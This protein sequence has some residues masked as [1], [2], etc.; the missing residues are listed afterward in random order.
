MTTRNYSSTA[1]ATT[2]TSP[3]N[4]SVT[5]M[6]VGATTGF[7]AAPFILILDPQVA[8]QELVLVTNVAGTTLT[9]TRGYDSTSAA[10]HSAGAVVKHAHGAIDFRDSATHVA[11]TT[12]VHGATGAVV[13]TTDTQSLTNKTLGATNTINGF[14]ASKVMVSDGSGKLAAGSGAAP[15]GAFVGTTDVQ[16]LSNKD[17]SAGTNV[18]PSAL[19]TDAEVTSAVSTHNGTT[20][21]HGATGAVVGTTNSQTLTNKTL[22]SPVINGPAITNG[23]INAA[24]FTGTYSFAMTGGTLNTTDWDTPSVARITIFGPL[25]LLEI[26]VAKKAASPTITANS[27]GGFTDTAVLSTIAGFS[28]VVT[29]VGV[30]RWQSSTASGTALVSTTGTVQLIDGYPTS[31]I[32]AGDVVRISIMASTA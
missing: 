31:T 29:G 9:I 16:T 14:G 19:A 30:G 17:L 20:V 15:S 22:T 5:S 11:A 25:W 3:I 8:G 4:N 7:P 10:S 24:S 6:V 27:V 2:L 18:F 12:G 26:T 13:G 32:V 1:A 23:T 21:A 28:G